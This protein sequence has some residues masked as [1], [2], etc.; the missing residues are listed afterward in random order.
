MSNVA[1]VTTNNFEN[2]VLKSNSPVLVDFWAA[3]C[4]PCRMVAPVIDQ[5][6]EQ[7]SGKVKV[8]K[9]NVDENPE[10]AEKYQILSIPTVYLFKNGSKAE[11]LVGARPKQSFEE[12]INKHV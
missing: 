2:E 12:M 10:I 3:W 9:L 1:A 7:Y 5:L 4:G 6:A 11:E 8:V